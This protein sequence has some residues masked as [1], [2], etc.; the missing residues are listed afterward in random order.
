MKTTNR[1]RHLIKLALFIAL[2][3]AL[4][5]T[6]TACESLGFAPA[7]TPE[8]SEPE[9]VTTSDATAI[10]TKD[11]AI[12]AVYQSLLA[13]ADSY[14]AKMYLS[15]FYTNCD[16]WYGESEYFKDGSDTWHVVVDMTESAYWDL[17]TYWQQASWFVFRDGKVIPSNLFEANAL[18]IEADLQALSPAPK[19]ESD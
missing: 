10:N 15:E 17:R 8:E 4:L 19:S 1:K 13:Q 7:S 2:L 6:V 5:G 16:N 12:M 3:V 11:T 9:P 14:D 18:R